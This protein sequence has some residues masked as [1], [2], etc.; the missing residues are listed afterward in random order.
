MLNPIQSLLCSLSASFFWQGAEELDNPGAD[1]GLEF[2]ELAAVAA[3]P[4]GSMRNRF[5]FPHPFHALQDLRRWAMGAFERRSG[6]C[7]ENVVTVRASIVDA[8]RL[9]ALLVPVDLVAF[10]ALGAMR[11]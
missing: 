2:S 1:V 6:P 10:A 8:P 4:L 3:Q 5:A 7:F 11:P 9:P